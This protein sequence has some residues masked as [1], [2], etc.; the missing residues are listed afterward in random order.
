MLFCVY[1]GGFMSKEKSRAQLFNMAERLVEEFFSN[2]LSIREAFTLLQALR[3]EQKVFLVRD[4]DEAFRRG[5]AQITNWRDKMLSIHYLLSGRDA[6]FTKIHGATESELDNYNIVKT[7]GKPKPLKY[8]KIIQIACT[9]EMSEEEQIEAS[10]VYIESYLTDKGLRGREQEKLVSPYRLRMKLREEFLNPEVA[11][12]RYKDYMGQL[13]ITPHEKKQVLVATPK[14]PITVDSL[15]S[16]ADIMM[17]DALYKDVLLKIEGDIVTYIATHG[18]IES[19]DLEINCKTLISKSERYLDEDVAELKAR[20]LIRGNL[21]DKE[22]F[23]TKKTI[24]PTPKELFELDAQIA[25]ILCEQEECRD[26]YVIK[27]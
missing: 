2:N 10:K 11:E 1:T 3:K 6:A 26:V 8:K 24:Y 4:R 13:G 20:E 25:S 16:C 19:E 17:L 15:E 5:F 7:K 9:P 12:R 21:V 18:K 14:R 22:M 23:F 27:V